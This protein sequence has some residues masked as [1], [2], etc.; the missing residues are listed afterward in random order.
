MRLLTQLENMMNTKKPL[1]AFAIPILCALSLFGTTVVRAQAVSCNIR[2]TT[3]KDRV[4][5]GEPFAIEFSTGDSLAPISTIPV[6]G[7]TIFTY[8]ISVDNIVVHRDVRGGAPGAPFQRFVVDLDGLGT[9]GLKTIS[10]QLSFTLPLNPA[11]P[12]C[13]TTVAG[14]PAVATTL[15]NVM[16]PDPIPSLATSYTGLWWNQATDGQGIFFTQNSPSNIAFIGWFT[17][18]KD[19]KQK[20]YA[21][22]RCDMNRNSGGINTVGNECITT[23][24]ET[25]NATFD[26][27]TFNASQ[28]KRTAVGEAAFKFMSNQAVTMTYNLNG[29]AGSLQLQRQPF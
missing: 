17:Y 29:V 14:R 21:G 9:S 2:V 12:N 24:Y 18:D 5:V 11:P 20:W 25:A 6:V 13:V 15:I 19:G 4:R 1:K 23:L 26:G 3:D 10:V 27:R 28:I 8:E 7:I 16:A 22:D